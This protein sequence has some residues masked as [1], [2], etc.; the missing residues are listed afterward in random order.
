M[1]KLVGWIALCTSLYAQAQ[2]KDF[3]TWGILNVNQT[4]NE[5]W[6]FNSDIQYRMYEDWDQLNQL[7]VRGG[8]G[9]HMSPNNNTILLGYAYV[10]TRVP[11]G[12]HQYSTFNE[13]RIYQQFNT[14]HLISKV[15]VNHRFRLEERLMNDDIFY[16]FRYQLNATLPLN[17]PNLQKDAWFIKASNELFLNAIKTNEFDRNRLNF[18]LGYVLS[19]M[20]TLEAGYM[21]QHVKHLQTDHLMVGLTINNPRT[22]KPS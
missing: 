5:D 12:E 22:K 13:H 10:L 21:K 7:L 8:I 3:R 17:K 1:R 19:P 18:N 14:K 2:E 20:L 16:R 15:N 9:Y 6:T 11:V 4:L